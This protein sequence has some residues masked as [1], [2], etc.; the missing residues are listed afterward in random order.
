MNRYTTETLR[1][2]LDIRDMGLP[3]QKLVN[4]SYTNERDRLIEYEGIFNESD[5]IDKRLIVEI[6]SRNLAGRL[7]VAKPIKGFSDER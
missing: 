3:S 1:A 6:R 2:Y 7:V 4:Y 5:L